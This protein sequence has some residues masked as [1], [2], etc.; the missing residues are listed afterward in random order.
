MNIIYRPACFLLGASLALTLSSGLPVFAND[1]E[2]VQEAVA[3]TTGTSKTVQFDLS[4]NYD[5]IQVKIACG[6]EKASEY[7]YYVSAPDGTKTEVSE[8][9]DGTASIEVSD[10][11]KGTW[12][13]LVEDNGVLETGTSIGQVD[14]SVTRASDTSGN[15]PGDSVDIK[16]EL[17]GLKL[18]FK[19]D[20]LVAE[21]TDESVASV[22]VRV[23]DT[24]SQE[25]FANTRVDNKY[26][27][28]PVPE[29]TTKVTVSLTP[30]TTQNIDGEEQQYT[31]DYN[32]HPLAEITFDDKEYTNSTAF[33]YT[34]VLQQEYSILI[35]DN[36][37][38]EDSVDNLQAGSHDLS[39]QLTEGINEI[40]AYVV[41]ENG[42]MRSTS[43]EV[44]LDTIPPTLMIES[45]YD[46]LE[47]NEDSVTFTGKVEDYDSIVFNNK[48]DVEVNYDG[49]F[50][51]KADLSEGENKFQILA[52]DKSGNEAAYTA[53]VT[54]V[55][56]SGGLGVKNIATLVMLAV[57]AAAGA[58]YYVIKRRGESEYV[59]VDENGNEVELTDEMIA[60]SHESESKSADAGDQKSILK[61]ALAGKRK[62]K[63]KMTNPEKKAEKKD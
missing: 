36:G 7:S 21:W 20:S 12:T 58:A 42:N 27:E 25:V 37:D 24:N 55:A 22:N 59:Y 49:T 60:D 26:I 38:L 40:T 33:S 19:D 5:K 2:T 41:D 46:G 9:N 10:A 43:T 47:T 39:M 34:A 13:V 28:V 17:A 32:N 57:I 1:G 23:F 63:Q 29:S 15:E 50:S 53:T 51:I 31:L 48:D 18:Y 30:A 52:K 61:R 44:T 14:V 4:D 3:Q 62:K 8:F 11:A 45:N 6:D 54:R 56:A 35:Y 16:K